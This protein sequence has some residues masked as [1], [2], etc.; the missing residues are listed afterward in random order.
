[1]NKCSKIATHQQTA[2][3]QTQH[4]VPLTFLD[5]FPV[6]DKIRFMNSCRAD[7]VSIYTPHLLLRILY[8]VTHV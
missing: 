8:R 7:I 6:S 2:G 4:N 1:M 5:F 3:K